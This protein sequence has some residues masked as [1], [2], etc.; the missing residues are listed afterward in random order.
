MNA[1]ARRPVIILGHT[2]AVSGA[3]LAFTRLAAE[4]RRRGVPVSVVLLAPG[5]LVEVL[6]SVG[7]PVTVLPSSTRRVGRGSGPLALA[8]S[9]LSMIGDGLRVGRLLRAH[10]AGILVAESTKTLFIGAIAG[11]RAGIPLVWQ[12]HDR[13]SAEYFGRLRTPLRLLGR[14]AAAGFLANSRGTLRTVRTGRRP[15]AV[16]HP[17]V[18]LAALPAPAAQRDADAVR[19]AMVGRIT[20]WKGQDLVLRALARMEATPPVRFVGGAHFGEDEYAAELLALTAELGL[21]DRVSFIGHV[22]DP[23]AEIAD[24]DIVVHYSRLAEPFGQ[25]IAEAMAGSRAVVAAAAGGPT[26]LIVDGHDGVLV[27]P[28]RPD[29]LAAALDRLVA[30]RELRVRLGA[31]ARERARDL[32]LRT[33]AA[34][35]DALLVRVERSAR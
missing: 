16:S 30:D 26:E 32:D 18:D 17:G 2:A 24:A 12:V 5:P 33:S 1:P 14:V 27:E 28:R 8:R 3:E 7:V 9:A 34:V 23:L 35:A 20:R 4:L 11:R 31:A 13:I 6:R 10:D 15:A 29:L 21:A 19:I 22:D 25:V